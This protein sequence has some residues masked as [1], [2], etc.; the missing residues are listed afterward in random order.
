MDID[1][2]AG[3]VQAAFESGSPD[4][5]H[6][7][8]A[9]LTKHLS[10]RDDKAI[11]AL[12][13]NVHLNH[14]DEWKEDSKSSGGGGGGTGTRNKKQTFQCKTCG[15]RQP[16]A[17]A[18]AKHLD[19]HYRMSRAA[20]KR[21]GAASRGWECTAQA[22]AD[23][24][25]VEAPTVPG[26]G[27]LEAKKADTAS[28]SSSTITTAPDTLPDVP[29]DETQPRCMICNEE[30]AVVKDEAQESWVYVGTMLVDVEAGGATKRD[31][32]DG[33]A[34]MTD[35][36]PPPEPAR[37]IVHRACA[38]NNVMPPLERAGS[39]STGGSLVALVPASPSSS[40]SS[41]QLATLPVMLPGLSLALSSL[42][43]SALPL[44]LLEAA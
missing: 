16:H 2:G 34:P 43:S 41:S 4:K 29:Q 31:D 18:I 44:P 25:K 3:L 26:P 36:L 23:D 40:S 37:R 1:A 13:E 32:Q 38:A 39:E 30:F 12:Y 11:S 9:E 15:L 5:L 21:V 17:D 42:S 14:A 35:A 19:W 22:W 24:G 27:E 28:S 7:A 10:V 6:D 33:D 8:L 20:S